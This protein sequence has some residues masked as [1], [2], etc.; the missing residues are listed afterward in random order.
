ML[1]GA[2]LILTGL[3]WDGGDALAAKARA[4]SQAFAAARAGAEALDRS[5]LAQGSVSLDDA[6]ARLAAQS[7]LAAAGTEGSIAITGT[8]V[9]VS[10]TASVPGGLL[11]LV[12][13][14]DLTVVGTAQAAAVP[15]S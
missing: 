11:G 7:S 10:V 15:G 1:A 8:T 5:A 14:H 2:F 4:S 6:A 12:G 3:V 13:V 9:S